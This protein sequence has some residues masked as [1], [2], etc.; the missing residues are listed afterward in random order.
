LQLAKI[1]FFAA[2]WPIVPKM[3]HDRS[4]T[5]ASSRQQGSIKLSEEYLEPRPHDNELLL[6]RL[7]E[8]SD[9]NEVVAA[10]GRLHHGYDL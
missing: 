10:I 5:D 6:A 7:V 1:K 4:A 8:C 3:C 9:R 2:R